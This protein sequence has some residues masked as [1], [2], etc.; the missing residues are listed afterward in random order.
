MH[1][2]RTGFVDVMLN[3]C[4]PNHS[5]GSREETKGDLLESTEVY[6][7]TPESRIKLLFPMN[8]SE[9]TLSKKKRVTHE[10]IT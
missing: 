9:S 5:C 1:T 2:T 6:T 8:L 3:N 10:E 4:S 7:S